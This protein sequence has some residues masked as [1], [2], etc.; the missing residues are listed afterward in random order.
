MY[1]VEK[2][3]FLHHVEGIAILDTAGDRIFAKYYSDSSTLNTIDGQLCLESAVHQA[4]QESKQSSMPTSNNEIII[5][6]NYTVVYWVDSEV[7]CLVVGK[8]TENEV[9][10]SSVLK[11]F[12]DS[13]QLELN[14]PFL[15]KRHLLMRYDAVL[16]TVDEM[17]D[18]GI[19]LETDPNNIANE[20]G[21]YIMDS[22]VEIAHKALS[23][24]N[25]Y[26]RD[27]L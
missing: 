15:A 20:V 23:S 7:I 25:K 18:A 12:V 5:I 14:A 1:L 9:V 16:L 21:P 8:R 27:N 11:T 2:M 24:M 22:S 13:L 6:G 19:I 4:V 26:L 10:L 17:L 3:D